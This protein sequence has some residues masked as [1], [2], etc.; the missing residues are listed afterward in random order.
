M[1]EE[2][3]SAN[4]FCPFL[5]CVPR[6]ALGGVQVCAQPCQG[7]KCGAWDLCQMLPANILAWLCTN[8]IQMPRKN[9]IETER[10]IL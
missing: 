8:A 3:P 10:P 4:K 7:D 2:K 5:T 1:K 6:Q 9:T